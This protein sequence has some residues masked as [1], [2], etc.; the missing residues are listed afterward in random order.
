MAPSTPSRSKLARITADDHVQF[1]LSCIRH[2]TGGGKIDFTKVANECGIVSKG[3]AAK[4]YERLLKAH[5][6]NP[7]GGSTVNSTTNNEK[8]GEDEADGSDIGEASRNNGKGGGGGGRGRKR[9]GPAAAAASVSGQKGKKVK[10]VHERKKK[11]AVARAHNLVEMTDSGDD[12][13]KLEKDSD[14]DASLDG[15]DMAR[16][17]QLTD[18]ANIKE[19]P[20][21][22]LVGLGDIASEEE[23]IT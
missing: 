11:L 6:I 12:R 1:L 17:E 4:R 15:D 21:L 13:V 2:A 18:E 7:A 14:D 23:S 3:A 10:T 22:D 9:K 19:E 5:Q 20:G 16:E 8:T